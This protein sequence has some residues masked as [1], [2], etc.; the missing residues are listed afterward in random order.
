[1]SEAA[2][3]TI[4]LVEDREENRYIVGRMLRDAGYRVIDAPTGQEGLNRVAE[5][6]DLI[7]LDVKLP[8]MLGYDVCRRLKS[9]PATSNIPVLH[10]S[11]T[12]I[13][14][15]S[16]VHALESGADGFLTQPV[17]P[18]VLIATVRSL[19]RMRNAEAISRFTARQ[20]QTTFDALS[21]GIGLLSL[22]GRVMRC[23]RAMTELL[24][25]SYSEIVGHNYSTL[26][27]ESLQIKEPWTE[28]LP[29]RQSKDVQ[30][31]NQWFAI[32]IDPIFSEEGA[33]SGRILVVAD[34]T[35]RKLAE[36][37]LKVT[38]KLAATGRLAHSIAHEINNPLSAVM[39]V[40]F[41]LD[42]EPQTD[43]GKQYLRTANAE[44][45]RVARITKQTLAF[46]RETA[47][48]MQVSLSDLLEGVV[49]L[50]GPQISARSVQ[51]EKDFRFSGTL[52]AFPG[53]L[54][55]VF[56]NLLSNALEAVPR[57]GRIRLRTRSSG[58]TVRV[59]LSD[60]GGGIPESIRKN[61]FEAFFTTK[62]LKGS[63]LG[64]WLTMG[65]VHKHH[66]TIRMR[67]TTIAGRSGTC[68]GISL[69]LRQA[70]PRQVMEKAAS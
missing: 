32:T 19:L 28:E 63:G 36:E 13:T 41:L 37:A 6:P 50:F 29:T 61:I 7:I 45:S 56:S 54:Q 30:S 42:R 35:D 33:L 31:G 27:Q 40:L 52:Q 11:A 55:Q 66:G 68:F 51:I 26:L 10:L 3:P 53:E 2:A 23:N 57:G 15:E 22:E 62:Q 5:H 1:M 20:W 14:N 48:P 46:H 4:L 9:N 21:E 69:P 67:S 49:N 24:R 25:R 60:N 64:L 59:L 58:S 34:I 17:E 12:F 44:L 43:A 38:E 39:N 70:H 65:I 18:T 16:R 47:E 8:D